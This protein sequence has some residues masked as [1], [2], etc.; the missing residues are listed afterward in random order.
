MQ[1]TCLGH[2]FSA[3]NNRIDYSRFAPNNIF[4]QP[5]NQ[6][7]INMIFTENRNAILKASRNFS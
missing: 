6:S 3:N 5:C 7:D 4:G 2:A 1:V